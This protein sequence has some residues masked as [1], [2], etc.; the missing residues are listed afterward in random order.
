MR[1]AEEAVSTLEDRVKASQV[2]AQ[3]IGNKAMHF[4]ER[5][6]L[7]AFE[8]AQKL[9]QTKDIQELVRIQT[10]FVQS[11]MR[12]L[13][14]QVKDL[15][16]TVSKAAI[17]SMKASKKGKSIILISIRRSPGWRYRSVVETTMTSRVLLGR[18]ADQLD[19]G[20]AI[21]ELPGELRFGLP[22]F[23]E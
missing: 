5:N 22:A 3:D 8:F 18:P 19:H 13:A 21:C 7:S 23:E 11:Q 6:V 20:E 17:D 2:G 15:G 1:A 4:A 10:E 9:L 16:D 12:V 14:E